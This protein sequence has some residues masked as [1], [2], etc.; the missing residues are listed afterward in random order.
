MNLPTSSVGLAEGEQI[1][2]NGMFLHSSV[3]QDPALLRSSCAWSPE[4]GGR[5]NDCLRSSSSS[6]YGVIISLHLAS[7]SP[8]PLTSNF[9]KWRNRF[10][11]PPNKIGSL[12][13]HLAIFASPFQ[14]FILYEYLG[15]YFQPPLFDVL[16]VK[17]LSSTRNI[18]KSSKHIKTIR[19]H[20]QSRF[21]YSCI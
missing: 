18:V 3:F 14:T 5:G 20:K 13:I 4:N 9:S 6:I 19:K 12:K 11:P 7:K 1:F 21:V 15:E 8:N 17:W 16:S 2:K 10:P